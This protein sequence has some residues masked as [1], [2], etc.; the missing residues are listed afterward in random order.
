[1]VLRLSTPT[2]PK[3]SFA[4]VFGAPGVGKSFL[5]LSWAFAVAAGKSWQ[6]RKVNGGPVIYIA[7]EGFGGLK[8]RVTALL[9]HEDYGV[10]TPCNFL[11]RPINLANPN[12]VEAFITEI[13]PTVGKPALIIIDTLARC[14]VGG[15]ENSARKWV[16][17]FMESR[18]SSEKLAPLSWWSIT[19]AR[20]KKVAPGDR[21]H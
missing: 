11:D 8:L 2:I 16:C 19:P 7:A 3:G 5:A 13:Q 1:M 20:T 18:Q 14:F 10:E 15:D 9:N 12:E 4:V 21:A 17:S 6:D